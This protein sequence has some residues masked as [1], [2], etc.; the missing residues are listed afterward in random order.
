MVIRVCTC[1]TPVI[2]ILGVRALLRDHKINLRGHEM[3]DKTGTIFFLLTYIVVFPCEALDSFSGR[4][5][6]LATQ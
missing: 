2:L 5:E 1:A 6:L 4:L 3:I